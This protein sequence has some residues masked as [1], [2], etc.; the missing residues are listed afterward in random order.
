[1]V[2]WGW[3]MATDGMYY[4]YAWSWSTTTVFGSF[5]AIFVLNISSRHFRTISSLV[6]FPPFLATCLLVRRKM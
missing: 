2:L 6:S 4:F 3:L 1:M 5:P